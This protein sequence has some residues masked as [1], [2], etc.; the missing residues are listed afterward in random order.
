MD[1]FAQYRRW[2]DYA[3][4]QPDLKAQLAEMAGDEQA[5]QAAF[6]SELEFGTAGLR[7]VIGVGTARMNLYTVARATQGLAEL[8]AATGP[9]AM[10]RGVAIAYDNRHMSQAFARQA[11][12][13][14][15]ANGIRAY[16]WPELKP[17]PM[18]SFT[19]RHLGCIAGIMITAS[20]NPAAYNG[21]KVY[22]EDGGQLP[23]E[24][25][26]RVLGYIGR[27]DVLTGAR[28]MDLD[29]A[30]AAGLLV[31]IDAPGSPVT[32]VEDAFLRNVLAQRTVA[33]RA[34]PKLK[35]LYS[36]LHGT[37]Y[38]PVTRALA[39]AGFE[40]AVVPGQEIPDPDF[41]TAP[42]PNPEKSACFDRA[43]A[44]AQEHPVDLI[45]ATD[46]DA[47]R[48]GVALRQGD[49]S[50]QVLNGNQI[51]C[52]LLSHI[53]SSRRRQGSLP[54]NAATVK[55]IVSTEMSRVIAEDF[56]VAQID[57]LTGFKFIAEQIHRFETTGEHTFI[58]GFEESQGYLTGGYCRDKDAVAAALLM[59]EYAAVL[60]E[61]GR[62]LADALEALYQ[63]YGY[64][65]ERSRSFAM[66]GL[67]GMDRVAR[68]LSA[69]RAA[70]PTRFGG[71]EVTAV[72][73]YQRQLRM[74]GQ[75]VE[76]IDL[77]PSNVLYY[78]LEQG[79]KVVVRPS[80]TEPTV[81][82][83]CAVKGAS[84]EEAAARLEALEQSAEGMILP[85]LK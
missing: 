1:A 78:E 51:G 61:Q 68:G 28:I 12:A 47:D 59:V 27:V 20:H 34:L 30:R 72:R 50:F 2:A 65:L 16:L 17:T 15:C 4:L 5:V 63:R 73:D 56:G 32:G 76:P 13:V 55:S 24:P 57:V 64:Y 3:P 69:L 85:L 29:A 11:A 7:A 10:G 45:I 21:Y 84:A 31:D 70:P 49:G 79:G 54:E 58:F 77:P 42:Y 18:L 41:P 71:W 66:E 38:I 19:V 75:T 9:E 60:A 6:G 52:L 82:V 35:V 36:P 37:G 39:M 46:P 25:S 8:I 23:P 80:G 67:D 83:Y 81:K 74:A 62:T 26:A 40:A 22:W 43:F 14:L 48:L 33:D 53:C 44:Y